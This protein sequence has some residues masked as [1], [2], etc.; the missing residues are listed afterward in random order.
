MKKSAQH[1]GLSRDAC[2]PWHL[3]RGML[4]FDAAAPPPSPSRVGNDDVYGGRGQR[5][6]Q[7]CAAAAEPRAPGILGCDD[8]PR[9]GGGLRGGREGGGR[10]RGDGVLRG[11][12][13]AWR[14]SQDRGET[15]C[16]LYIVC[17]C[18][19]VCMWVSHFIAW[20]FDYRDLESRGP[21]HARS[22]AR[23]SAVTDY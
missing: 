10:G 13:T 12:R 22:R 9:Q 18:V 3:S 2:I 20:T 7:V 16:E 19:F 17:M 6:V 5:A 21:F 23:R 1:A 11:G 4:S 14:R 8:G 15:A